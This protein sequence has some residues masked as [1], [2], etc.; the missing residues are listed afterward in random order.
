[1]NR[2]YTKTYYLP[3]I[4]KIRAKCPEASITTDIIVGF[5]TETKK[6]FQ[7]TV[8]VIKKVQFDAA[9]IF[10]YSPRNGTRA[11][12]KYKDNVA[13]EEKTRRIV[14][15]NE[16]QRK[17]SLAKNQALLNRTQRILIDGKSASGILYGRTDTHKLVSFSASRCSL[18]QFVDVRIV[19]ASVNGLT[20]KFIN[21]ASTS[22]PGG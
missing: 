17:I 2:K 4:K 5:P 7:D 14:L 15:L 10:K 16:L 1:M 13:T 8:D 20:G 21:V 18:G 3:L 11:Q 6:D 9:F 12:R 19:D 22:Q